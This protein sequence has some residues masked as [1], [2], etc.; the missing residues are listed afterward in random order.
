MG[1]IP[2]KTVGEVEESKVFVEHGKVHLGDEIGEEVDNTAVKIVP[3]PS[4][5]RW[6]IIF[7]AV[8]NDV[9]TIE[10][11][12][13]GGNLVLSK[14]I[15]IREGENSLNMDCNRCRSGIYTVFVKG[16]N[17]DVV[18]KVNIISE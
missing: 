5:G 6:S 17:I 7:T 10:L 14:E 12:D 13:G 16:S 18:Q 11:Y 2:R 8:E 15:E 9:A 3:N 4:K 1:D